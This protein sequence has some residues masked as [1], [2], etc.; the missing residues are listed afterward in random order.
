MKKSMMPAVLLLISVTALAWFM[1]RPQP[2]TANAPEAGPSDAPGLS[3]LFPDGLVTAEGKPVALDALQDKVIGVY[4]SAQWCGPC[5]RFTPELVKYYEANRDHFEVV[6][7]SSDRS[8]DAK[9]KYMTEADMA[10]PAVKWNSDAANALKSRYE[11]RGIPTLVMLRDDG[12]TLTRD[13]RSMVMEGTP[14][15]R[16]LSARLETEEYMCGQCDKV[17]TRQKLVYDR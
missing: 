1:S 17:H 2:S 5:R 3:G 12:S 14:A 11:V 9:S 16:L 7:V 13:G 15:E 8:E 6:F 10:W 4:F